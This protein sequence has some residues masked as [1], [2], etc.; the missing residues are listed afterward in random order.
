MDDIARQTLI[1][2]VAQQGRDVVENSRRC[3][4]LLRD[5]APGHKREIFVLVSALEQG[6]VNDLLSLQGQV[7]AGILLAQVTAKLQA[8]LALTEEAARWAVE[9]WALALG[10]L[11]SAANAMDASALAVSIKLAHT[12]TEHQAEVVGLAFSPD[13]QRL[14]SA[15]MDGMAIVWS[16]A[17][18]TVQHRCDSDTGVLSCVAFSPDATLIAL[19]GADADIALWQPENGGRLWHLLGH[20]GDVTGVAFTPDG[21]TL[22][23]GSRD[24]TLRWW[25][26]ETR[27]ERLRVQAHA[28]GVRGLALSSNGQRLTSAGG[29]DRSIKIWD[30]SNGQELHKL[31]G[32]TSQVTSVAFGPDSALLASGSWDETVLLW[33]PQRSQKPRALVE[34]GSLMALVFTVTLSPDARVLVSGSWDTLLRV[35]D[36]AQGQLLRKLGQHNAMVLSTACSADGTLLAS[37]DAEG[38]VLLWR[39][40]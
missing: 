14:V 23:S 22:I 31:T 10:V 11:P 7:P 20:S 13:S 4:A 15:G 33:E 30:V 2:L 9:S 36:A 19:G 21:K 17:D 37:G 8:A 25:D 24:G 16:T 38:K 27:T 1:Q 6:V 26:L 18:G 34:K 40:R 32:H 29:W 28:D 12:L 35:W 39:M 5:L 3:N